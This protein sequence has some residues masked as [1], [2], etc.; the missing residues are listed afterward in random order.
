MIRPATITDP[1]FAPYI[2]SVDARLDAVESGLTNKMMISN[3][4]LNLVCLSDISV[5]FTDGDSITNVSSY[6]PSGYQL[7]FVMASP[8]NTSTISVTGCKIYN[9]SN[10]EIKC[11]ADFTG[12]TDFNIML[13]VR[14]SS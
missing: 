2:P 13:F 8:V 5:S 12:N 10:V 4:P 3:Y 6:I 14:K 1:T 9:N 11:R 7:S